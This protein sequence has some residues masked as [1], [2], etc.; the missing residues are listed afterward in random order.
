MKHYDVII[1]GAGPGGMEAARVAA[2]EG[3]KVTLF[4]KSSVKGGNMLVACLF[5]FRGL[6]PSVKFFD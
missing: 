5:L 4:E 3:N 2:L 1:V 6:Q